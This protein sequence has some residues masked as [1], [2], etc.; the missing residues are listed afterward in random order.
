[1]DFKQAGAREKK[2]S[3]PI[4]ELTQVKPIY[5]LILNTLYTVNTR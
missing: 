2:E 1:M 5:T 4:F 3:S